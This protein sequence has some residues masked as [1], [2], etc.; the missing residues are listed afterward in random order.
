MKEGIPKP[1]PVAE[2]GRSVVGVFGSRTELMKDLRWGGVG[3]AVCPQ[4][5]CSLLTMTEL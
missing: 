1:P 4:V 2:R 3:S 5:L